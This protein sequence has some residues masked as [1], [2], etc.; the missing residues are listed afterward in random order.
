[1]TAPTAW[2]LHNVVHGRRAQGMFTYNPRLCSL[3]LQGSS[4]TVLYEAW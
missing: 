1:M 4:G 2:N 3:L